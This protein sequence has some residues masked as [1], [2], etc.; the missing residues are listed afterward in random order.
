MHP[1][2]PCQPPARTGTAPLESRHSLLRC[3]VVSCHTHHSRPCHTPRLQFH[4][5]SLHHSLRNVQLSSPVG[6]NT[7]TIMGEVLGLITTTLG[8]S[9]VQLPAPRMFLTKSTQRRALMDV[10][11]LKCFAALRGAR[12]GADYTPSVTCSICL[13]QSRREA[14]R[15]PRDW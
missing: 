13:S 2:H 9:Q 5:R 10:N 14:S 15:T 8:I 3:A 6:F 12:T 11:V 7:A 1:W 4:L